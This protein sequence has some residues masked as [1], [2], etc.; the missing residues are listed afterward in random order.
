MVGSI[1]KQCVEEALKNWPKSG[2][3]VSSNTSRIINSAVLS[4]FFP[5]LSLIAPFNEI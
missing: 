3:I 5:A 1:A 4:L 2:M